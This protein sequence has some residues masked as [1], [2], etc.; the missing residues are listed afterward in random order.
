MRRLLQVG[1]YALLQ[2]A[3]IELCVKSPAVFL[4][5]AEAG[6][7]EL[8]P[9]LLVRLE[10]VT[11]SLDLI[12][13]RPVH[14]TFGDLDF[15]LVRF[16]HENLLVDQ[17]IE[18]VTRKRSLPRR[19][20]RKRE[21]RRAL[22]IDEREYVTPEKRLRSDDGDNPVYRYPG[23]ARPGGSG[24]WR[25]RR[26]RRSRSRRRRRRHLGSKLRRDAQQRDKK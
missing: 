22:L 17:L 12:V 10:L 5:R 13:H 21:A 7:P 11:N 23:D 19:I 15:H 20:G 24:C 8:G 3:P 14:L 1:K 9:V 26:G 16:L 2:R 18:R 25:R 6:I 4:R